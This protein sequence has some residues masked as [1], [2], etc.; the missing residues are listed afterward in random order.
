MGSRQYPASLAMTL[1]MFEACWSTKI[2]QTEGAT[3]S[4]HPNLRRSVNLRLL[5][6]VAGV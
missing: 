6:S 2:L 4:F 1:P 3:L 5:F